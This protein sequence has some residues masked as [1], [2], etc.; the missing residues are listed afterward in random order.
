MPLIPTVL[1]SGI[2]LGLEPLIFAKTQSS[3]KAAMAKFKE[4]SEKQTG[5]EGKDVFNAANTAASL[6]FANN[7]KQLA[8]DI[9]MVVSTNV[10][11]YIKTA[12]II[13]PP[14]IAVTTAGSPAAQAGASIAPSPPAIIT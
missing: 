13:I 7:M 11:A 6:E 5:N 2:Q 14:G 12:T 8:N 3:F 4:V 1:K 10:D 9:A